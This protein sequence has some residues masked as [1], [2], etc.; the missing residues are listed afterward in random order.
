MD[1]W[2]ETRT[3]VLQ[4]FEKHARALFEQQPSRRSAMLVVAQYWS[5]GADDEVHAELICSV[6][7]TPV[8]PHECS[9][10]YDSDGNLTSTRLVA[11]EECCICSDW[12][13]FR[14][15]FYG[16]DSSPIVVAFEMFCREGAT[17]DMDT[18][19]AYT[20]YAI[21]HRAGDG[22]EIEVLGVPQRPANAVTGCL[23]EASDPWSDAR[24]RALFD[25]ICAAPDDD[26][27][28]VVLSDLLLS[29]H[30]DDPR[31]QAIALSLVRA[32]DAASRARRDELIAT[33][34]V[35]WIHPLG[36]VIP[37]GCAWF[38]RGFLSRAHVYA[39]SAHEQD[40]AK[41][42]AAWGTVEV[43][44]ISPGSYDVIDPSMVSL[45]DVGPLGMVGLE[46]LVGARRPWAIERLHVALDDAGP[47]MELELLARMTVLPHLREL[48]VT[49]GDDAEL[50]MA[51][52][53][54]ASPSRTPWSSQLEQLTLVVDNRTP[55]TRWSELRPAHASLAVVL[56]GDDR[57]PAGWQVRFDPRD[58]IEITQVG[59]HPAATL[60]QLAALV[61]ACPAGI[62]IRLGAT[63]IRRCG[64]DE[65]RYVHEH[66]GR[67]V[68]VV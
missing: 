50:A 1:P 11:G 61:N 33:H 20:P 42:A 26:G 6:R 53:G 63:A 12:E 24:R 39:P 60:V 47:G 36:A 67:D 30:P 43:L 17:Q 19:E 41:G 2:A 4:R 8:W 55:I 29:S 66:T 58:I 28:R 37:P 25:E 18:S 15:D 46:A 38:E 5:D 54:L 49:T 23:P 51:A 9:H 10:D 62:P 40:I 16:A 34:L 65:V 7:E 3:E 22:V 59:W 45:R 27:P 57:Q 68:A 35:E 56:A 31:G 14:F 64:P 48:V 32:P 52:A 44:R 21:A 13:S